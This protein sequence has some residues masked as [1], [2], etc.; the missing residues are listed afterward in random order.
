M[1]A[2]TPRASA[3]RW[4]IRSHVMTSSL[5]MCSASPVARSS[6]RIPTRP[7]AKSSACVSVQS[8]VPSPGTTTS[9]PRA[10]RSTTV[11]SPASGGLASS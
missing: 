10:M 5:V 4:W 7:T 11:Q 6:P 2:S 1:R 9:S 3:T 8:E